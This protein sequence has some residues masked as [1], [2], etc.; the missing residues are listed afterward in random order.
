MGGMQGELTP[1]GPKQGV[2]NY[3]GVESGGVKPQGSKLVGVE[4][5]VFTL[6]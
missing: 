4:S 2:V 3:Q 1:W 5:L 6:G